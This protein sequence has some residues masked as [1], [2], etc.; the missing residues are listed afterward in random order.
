[1]PDSKQT[2]DVARYA[3][4]VRAALAHLPDAGREILLEDLES[5]LEEVASESGAPL[6]ERLG[7]PA[8]YAA[9]LRSAYGAIDS[10]GARRPVRDRCN[11]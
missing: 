11:R 3:A 9:E 4:D 2:D 7:N 5:H 8:D 1:M 6:R 10:A